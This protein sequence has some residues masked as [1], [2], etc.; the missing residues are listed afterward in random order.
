MQEIHL[1]DAEKGLPREHLRLWQGDISS[2]QKPLALRRSEHRGPYRWE[3]E[4]DEVGSD[5][6]HS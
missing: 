4:A 6:C 3:E 5:C 1:V 2:H